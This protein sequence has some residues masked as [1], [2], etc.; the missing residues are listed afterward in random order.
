MNC[1]TS[2]GF[3]LVMLKEIQGWVVHGFGLVH[4][5]GVVSTPS[6][7]LQTLNTTVTS[8]LFAS[9]QESQ[10]MMAKDELSGF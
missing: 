3:D 10:G 7:H 6:A 5:C 8:V 2:I 9:E 1:T 4:A